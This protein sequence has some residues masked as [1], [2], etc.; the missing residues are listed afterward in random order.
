MD[1]L[2]DT[3][4]LAYIALWNHVDDEGRHTFNAWELERKIPRSSFRGRWDEFLRTFEEKELIIVYEYPPKKYFYIRT[5]FRHQYI[6][7]PTP[8]TIPRPPQ[9]D[10]IK[11]HREATRQAAVPLNEGIPYE[12]IVGLWNTYMGKHCPVVKYDPKDLH[13]VLIRTTW[14]SYKERQSLEWWKELFQYMSTSRFLTGQVKEFMARLRWTLIPDN[15]AKIMSGQYHDTDKKTKA[16][17]RF[18][19]A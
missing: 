8:S 19:D 5:W 12:D 9:G 10:P 17:R 4:A 14:M 2:S 1:G 3:E 11:E 6:N 18:T 7:K 13:L 16:V 15:L